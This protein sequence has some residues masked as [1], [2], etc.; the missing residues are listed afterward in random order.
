MHA[1]KGD[2]SILILLD[3]TAAFDTI[4]HATLLD[5]LQ[6]WVGISGTALNWFHPYLTNRVFK[7]AL[8]IMF[9][10]PLPC[11]MVSLRGRFLVQF[12]SPLGHLFTRFHDIS[13]HCYADDTQNYLSESESTV[14][15]P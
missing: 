8:I 2:S 15:S 7:S 3:L 6:N 12:C 13:Y 10:L 14:L 11:S 4:A 1:D 9:P 5:R